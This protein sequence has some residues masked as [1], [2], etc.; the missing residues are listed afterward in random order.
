M[1][2][3]VP[4]WRV[5]FQKIKKQS[6][7]AQELFL[8]FP[9]VGY[10]MLETFRSMSVCHLQASFWTTC[11]PRCIIRSQPRIKQTRYENSNIISTPLR[12]WVREG[13]TAIME[14]G[15]SALTSIGPQARGKRSAFRAG[16]WTLRSRTKFRR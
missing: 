11:T 2:F 9:K 12:P 4:G 6:E 14:G 8:F 16:P 10:F 5:L 3:G 13:Q 7:R 1:F 15:G